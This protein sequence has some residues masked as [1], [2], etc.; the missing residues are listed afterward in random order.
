MSE[1]REK[2]QSIKVNKANLEYIAKTGKINGSL[3]NDLEAV[4]LEQ[5][6]KIKRLEEFKN[7]VIQILNTD[8]YDSQDVIPEDVFQHILDQQDK[9]EMVRSIAFA[10]GS[11]QERM[12]DIKEFLTKD[13]S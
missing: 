6:A 4:F 13:E 5:Q 9:I 10:E 8:E 11:S 12:F 1:I 2:I 3:L 7:S